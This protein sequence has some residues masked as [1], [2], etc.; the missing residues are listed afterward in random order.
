MDSK[1]WILGS[2]PRYS[3]CAQQ[4]WNQTPP[5]LLCI[6]DQILFGALL[7]CKQTLKDT[8]LPMRNTS[9]CQAPHMNTS[10]A[11]QRC[12]WSGCKHAQS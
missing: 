7:L 5:Q 8:F 4:L 11:R 3:S 9:P 1:R 12:H 6:Q 2:K 10:A